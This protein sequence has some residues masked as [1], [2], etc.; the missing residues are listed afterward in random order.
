LQD[1]EAGGGYS[2]DQ[3]AARKNGRRE[4]FFWVIFIVGII[5]LAVLVW[6]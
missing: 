3:D 5:A 6:R 4:L 1:V 2:V